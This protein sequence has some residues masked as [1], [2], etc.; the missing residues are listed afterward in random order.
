[1]IMKVV[2]T[3]CMVSM[4]VVKIACMVSMKIMTTTVTKMTAEMKLGEAQKVAMA[5]VTILGEDYFF[6]LHISS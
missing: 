2:K 3:I 1:M 4:E 5:G 6:T